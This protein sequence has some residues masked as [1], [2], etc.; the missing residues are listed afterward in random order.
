VRREGDLTTEYV[1]I[2]D[3][4]EATEPGQFVPVYEW[5]IKY[6]RATAKRIPSL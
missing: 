5:E 4:F 1:A 2:S 3:Q 6:D